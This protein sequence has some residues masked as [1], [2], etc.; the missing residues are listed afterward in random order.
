M[1][2][3]QSVLN[4]FNV[5]NSAKGNIC[6][7]SSGS[8]EVCQP[9][10]LYLHLIIYSTVTPVLPSWNIILTILIDKASKLFFV[11]VQKWLSDMIMWCTDDLR[12]V[13]HLLGQEAAYWKPEQD[14]ALR[15]NGLLVGW[16]C[17]VIWCYLICNLSWLGHSTKWD[18]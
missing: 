12:S 4:I 8:A 10:F 18:S 16:I 3:K 15:E 6:V 9:L 14:K 13:R 17:F 7:A 5:S 1:Q 2:G 11:S